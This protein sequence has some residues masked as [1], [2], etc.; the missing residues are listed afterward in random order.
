MLKPNQIN[1]LYKH[2]VSVLFIFDSK[3]NILMQLR[4]KNPDIAAPNMWG[5][6]GGRCN[7]G[8]TPYQC[9][10][11]ETE[12]ETGY[13]PKKIYWHKNIFIKKNINYNQKEHYL[14]IF[15]NNYDNLSKINCF[16]GQKIIFIS[17]KEI[18]KLNTFK[19]NIECIKEILKIK[20]KYE[21]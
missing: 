19:H 12:E 3:N 11:R 6:V 15:W 14:S 16:E 1:Y 9:C 4:D 5:P 10:V 8:E 21:E 20:E 18:E 17:L 13:S 7:I 2:F